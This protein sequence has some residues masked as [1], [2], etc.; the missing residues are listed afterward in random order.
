MY[1][2][3]QRLS[4]GVIKCACHSTDCGLLLTLINL[5]V[6][7]HLIDCDASEIVV[8]SYHRS[9]YLVLCIYVSEHSLSASHL[10]RKCNAWGFEFWQ[11]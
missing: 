10:I 9:S 7:K 11:K 1:G 2:I 5:S 6:T 3:V 4:G 8:D